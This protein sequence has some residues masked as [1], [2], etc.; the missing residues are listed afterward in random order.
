MGIEINNRIN[1]SPFQKVIPQIK[2][3]GRIVISRNQ[4]R[5]VVVKN[6]QIEQ[7]YKPIK[8]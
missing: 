8:R 4:S 1:R 2:V 7:V 3:N 5:D 6:K